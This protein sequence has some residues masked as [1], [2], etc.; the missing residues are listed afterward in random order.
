[1]GPW[2]PNWRPDPTGRR[3]EAIRAARRGALAAAVIFGSL[4]VVATVVSMPVEFAP[5]RREPRRRFDARPV[6]PPGSRTAWGR[7]HLGCARHAGDG[8]KR[9]A[10]DGG[11]GPR[12]SGH[13]GDD[14]RFCPGRPRRRGVRS[15]GWGGHCR[16]PVATRGDCRG[17]DLAADRHRVD[18]L[19]LTR[20]ASRSAAG[21]DGVCRSG[22][23]R[24][25]VA[26]TRTRTSSPRRMT[27]GRSTS[28]HTPNIRSLP[29]TWPRY[30]L[31]ARSVS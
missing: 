2:D 17:P 10:G 14:R 13:L 18:R 23:P 26:Q 4:E 3:L 24:P 28:P 30:S 11:R 8:S 19:G 20:P 21:D 5:V 15:D 31:I 16:R 22:E 12:S 27:P 25:V 6:Q 29:S 7:S 1:M 9:R